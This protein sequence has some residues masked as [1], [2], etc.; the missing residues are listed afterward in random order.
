MEAN[1]MYL[2]LYRKRKILAWIVKKAI[3]LALIAIFV[4]LLSG[5]YRP[6]QHKC[7]GDLHL[8]SMFKQIRNMKCGCHIVK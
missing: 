8:L 2:W 5:G 3:S 1:L 6:S 7:A 4:V